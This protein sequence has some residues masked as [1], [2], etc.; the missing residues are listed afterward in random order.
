MG[1]FAAELLRQ[2]GLGSDVAILSVLAQTAVLDSGD[3]LQAVVG[4]LL[5]HR[6]VDVE[7]PLSDE[8]AALAF[9]ALG[10]ALACLIA[11]TVGVTTLHLFGQLT[12]GDLG[13]EWLA[14]WA[15]DTLGLLLFAPLTLLWLPVASAP[16]RGQAA[17]I[18]GPLPPVALPGWIER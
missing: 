15:G 18:V 1:A 2:A 5:V 16:W 17:L 11:A 6:L 13:S 8:R 14:W 3:A 4:A 12:R 7:Q 10:G 9:F